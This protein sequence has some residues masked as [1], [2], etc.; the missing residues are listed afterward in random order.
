[1]RSVRIVV[2]RAKTRSKSSPE[3]SPALQNTDRTALE[4]GRLQCSPLALNAPLNPH[5]S[6]IYSLSFTDLDERGRLWRGIG[7][8]VEWRRVHE[9]VEVAQLPAFRLTEESGKTG[10]TFNTWQA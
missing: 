10:K 2:C 5:S 1:M 7:L 4:V 6:L 9:G 8:A 3:L